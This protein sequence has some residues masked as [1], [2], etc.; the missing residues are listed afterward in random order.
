M[1]NI[2]ERLV[3]NPTYI[4]TSF[5]VVCAFKLQLEQVQIKMSCGWYGYCTAFFHNSFYFLDFI[6]KNH[7][8][9]HFLFQKL[10]V[11]IITSQILQNIWQICPLSSIS[12]AVIWPKALLSLTWIKAVAPVIHSPPHSQITLFKILI[13]FCH[14]SG[15]NPPMFSHPTWNKPQSPFLGL[16]SIDSLTQVVLKKQKKRKSFPTHSMK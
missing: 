12:P 4:N 15:K 8:G 11:R 1:R 2:I 5:N 9:C 14:S 7:N 13:K 6:F 10:I 3:I 16:G